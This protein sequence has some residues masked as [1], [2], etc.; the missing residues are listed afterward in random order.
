M[1]EYLY[2][3]YGE[4]NTPFSTLQLKNGELLTANTESDREFA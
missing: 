2:D 4:N 1:N 3:I